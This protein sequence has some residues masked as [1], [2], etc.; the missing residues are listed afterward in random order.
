MVIPN[1]VINFQNVEV[2]FVF[3]EILDLSSAHAC[4]VVCVNNKSI[5]I[6]NNMGQD[7]SQQLIMPLSHLAGLCQRT[8]PY[9]NIL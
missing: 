2:S 7:L 5:W 3:Y 6:Y 4:R 1:I 8:S 9:I